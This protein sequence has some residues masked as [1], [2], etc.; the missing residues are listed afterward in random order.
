MILY[1][2]FWVHKAIGNQ[3]YQKQLVEGWK[4][5]CK[6]ENWFFMRCK[7]I[8][9][10]PYV[11]LYKIAPVGRPFWIFSLVGKF[12]NHN[13][14]WR[15]LFSVQFLDLPSICEVSL[16]KRFQKTPVSAEFLE[17][18]IKRRSANHFRL[19]QDGH[20]FFPNA[21]RPLKLQ[22]CDSNSFDEKFIQNK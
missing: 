20:V 18:V 8:V 19:L 4:F 14:P 12:L 16:R 6:N 13:V 5:V 10:S 2:T 15:S 17:F 11:T 21:F 3:K 22:M 7:N 1:L 9:I